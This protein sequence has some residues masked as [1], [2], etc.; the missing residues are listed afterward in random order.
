MYPFV[1][2]T[3]IKYCYNVNQTQLYNITDWLCIFSGVLNPT[4]F[5]GICTPGPNKTVCTKKVVT[6]A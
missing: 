4:T 6:F 2:D 1:D 5:F 3:E